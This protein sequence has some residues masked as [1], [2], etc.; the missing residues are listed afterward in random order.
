MKNICLGLGYSHAVRQHPRAEVRRVES[1]GRHELQAGEGT[2]G[3][4]WDLGD[5]RING[6]ILATLATINNTREQTDFHEEGNTGRRER[7]L[8]CTEY[9]IL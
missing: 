3:I 1:P 2:H 9:L 6:P 4:H 8:L 5:K 7:S